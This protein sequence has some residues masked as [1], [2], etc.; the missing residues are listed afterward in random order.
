MEP[1]VNLEKVVIFVVKTDIYPTAGGAHI[2]FFNALL[3][4][5]S[6]SPTR[7]LKQ[8]MKPPVE[9]NLR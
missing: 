2:H 1:L 8:I 3:K 4:L 5:G 7:E 9:A 6:V